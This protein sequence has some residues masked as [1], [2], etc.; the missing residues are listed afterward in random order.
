MEPTAPRLTS[1]MGVA[2]ALLSALS[3][4]EA[5]EILIAE[6]GWDLSYQSLSLLRGDD[7]ATAFGL[8]WEFLLRE[9][10]R[11]AVSTSSVEDL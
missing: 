4:T 2:S 9:D 7:A 5:V 10:L 1:V 11:R 3:T 6:F 8:C